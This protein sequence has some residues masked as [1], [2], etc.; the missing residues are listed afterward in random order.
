M[1]APKPGE[2]ERVP[3]IIYNGPVQQLNVYLESIALRGRVAR[4]AETQQRHREATQRYIEAITYMP[5]MQQDAISVL[6][7]VKQ[8]LDEPTPN[9]QDD[10]GQQENPEPPIE[11]TTL[12]EAAPT[13]DSL[14]QAVK[15]MARRLMRI[16]HPDKQNP[17]AEAAFK[18]E[19]RKR[20]IT[21][22]G[23]ALEDSA[24]SK[25][26]GKRKA[27]LRKAQE[28]FLD[29]IPANYQEALRQGAENPEMLSDMRLAAY[30][31]A[32]IS[33]KLSDEKLLSGNITEQVVQQ[34]KRKA[35]LQAPSHVAADLAKTLGLLAKYME[36]HKG[37]AT[38]LAQ[39]EEVRSNLG[40][41]AF[42]LMMNAVREETFFNPGIEVLDNVRGRINAVAD[43]LPRQVLLIAASFFDSDLV[44]VSE[45]VRV[46]NEEL[47]PASQALTQLAQEYR[48][49]LTISPDILR[50]GE[51]KELFALVTELVGDDEEKHIPGKGIFVR[52]RREPQGDL[53]DIHVRL[54][55]VVHGDAYS[56]TSTTT[57]CI[58]LY[59]HWWVNS[60]TST[61]RYRHH[62]DSYG[63]SFGSTMIDTDIETG[64]GSLFSREKNTVYELNEIL[65]SL[66]RKPGHAAKQLPLEA[67]ATRQGYR[68][69]RPE[70]LR[71]FID[72]LKKD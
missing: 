1:S 9:R 54:L 22:V 55:Q 21:T 67:E 8:Q 60:H 66:R 40:L 46:L 7:L 12:E 14:E 24:P 32:I 11:P 41:S 2:S 56:S 29:T 15:G 34:I 17:V 6:A 27:A 62:Y 57:N 33:G 71:W 16:L 51:T 26:E 49:G 30:I 3:A 18:P 50:D 47:L 10:K 4:R 64:F 53:H 65:G 37:D 58:L 72:E 20:L 25:R 70:E 23:E 42:Q 35:D 31:E 68:I 45:A 44:P 52:N 48:H 69:A 38:V 59:G 39:V 13:L 5:P 61:H 19:E 43:K 63:S 28:A 36:E